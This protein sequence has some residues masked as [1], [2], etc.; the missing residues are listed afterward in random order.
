MAYHWLCYC[1]NGYV[2]GLGPDHHHHDDHTQINILFDEAHCYLLDNRVVQFNLVPFEMC[3]CGWSSQAHNNSNPSEKK[4][5]SI[6]WQNFRVFFFFSSCWAIDLT[7][8]LLACSHTHTLFSW[9]QLRLKSVLLVA[10][11]CTHTPNSQHP[12]NAWCKAQ[13]SVYA[14][15]PMEE[16]HQIS[17]YRCIAIS[18]F[19]LVKW[20][21]PKQGELLHFQIVILFLSFSH[22]RLREKM[23]EYWI[24]YILILSVPWCFIGPILFN[25]SIVGLG[26]FLLFLLCPR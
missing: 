9:R 16:A 11:Q 17:V 12:G 15:G 4:V 14:S 7:R 18:F 19:E 6:W 13:K 10:N 24:W 25:R 8:W 21:W 22:R 5:N 23:I 2:L 26:C 20:W 1:N 3:V